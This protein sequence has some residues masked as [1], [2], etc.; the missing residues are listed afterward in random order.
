MDNIETLY[1]S[2][3]KTSPYFHNIARTDLNI[4]TK[5]IKYSVLKCKLCLF[6]YQLNG[7]VSRV[8]FALLHVST[9]YK[10]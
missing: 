5:K 6:F 8:F 10:N 7:C 1:R 9:I 3:V 2:V 4:V